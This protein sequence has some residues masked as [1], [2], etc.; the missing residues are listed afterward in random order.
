MEQRSVV[1][2]PRAWK[3]ASIPLGK[4]AAS[5]GIRKSGGVGPYKASHEY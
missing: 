3:L 4:H 2:P 1:V 5:A